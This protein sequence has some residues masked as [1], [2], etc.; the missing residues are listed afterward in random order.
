LKNSGNSGKLSGGAERW[1]LI[2]ARPGISASLK[3]NSIFP[4]SIQKTKT[5]PFFHHNIEIYE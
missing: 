4:K 3:K 1:T 5:T 2:S